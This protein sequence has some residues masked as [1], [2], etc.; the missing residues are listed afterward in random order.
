MIQFIMQLGFFTRDAPLDEPAPL[1]VGLL[2]EEAL[3]LD[4]HAVQLGVDEP[5]HVAARP[6]AV[7]VVVHF[8]GVGLHQQDVAQVQDGAQEQ[9]LS[10]EEPLRAA[11]LQ[12]AVLRWDELLAPSVDLLRVH[13]LVH[14]PQA[15]GLELLDGARP[16]APLVKHHL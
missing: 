7:D 8:P 10:P 9:V 12:Q 14:A 6:H 4:E 13:V 15:V 11:G 16:L 2:L 3:V 1:Y 5:Q